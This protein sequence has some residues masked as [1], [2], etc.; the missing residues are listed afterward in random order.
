MRRFVEEGRQIQ[1]VE[2]DTKF[3]DIFDHLVT[4]TIRQHLDDKEFGIPFG[5][6]PISNDS[7]AEHVSTSQ[8]LGIVHATLAHPTLG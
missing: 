5:L 8:S 4:K 3:F 7:G 1:A 2:G 6:G